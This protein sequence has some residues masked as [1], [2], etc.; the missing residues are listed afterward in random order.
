MVEQQSEEQPEVK[1]HQFDALA[2]KSLK[3]TYSPKS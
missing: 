2:H 3:P 1:D